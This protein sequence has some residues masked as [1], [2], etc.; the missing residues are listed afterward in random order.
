MLCRCMIRCTKSAI[1]FPV[2]TLSKIR[3]LQEQRTSQR[4]LKTFCVYNYNIVHRTVSHYKECFVK[5]KGYAGVKQSNKPQEAVVYRDFITANGHYFGLT[6]SAIKWQQIKSKRLAMAKQCS[7][8]E[9]TKRLPSNTDTATY[10][11]GD[12]CV[13]RS[14]LCYWQFYNGHTTN[15]NQTSEVTIL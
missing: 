13:T 3:I 8:S 6:W 14:A 1:H 4:I 15:Q 2:H 12:T 10:W 5:Q 9:M 7:S 11:R